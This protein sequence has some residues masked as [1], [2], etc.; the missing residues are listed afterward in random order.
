MKNK[1]FNPDRAHPPPGE[2]IKDLLL[3]KDI[4]WD[5]FGCLMGM[6]TYEVRMLLSGR[7]PIDLD[8][9][10]QLV[11]HLGSNIEFW[12]ELQRLYEENL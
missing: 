8:I 3:D 6:R 2:T 5:E 4:S 11:Y 10:V 7:Y 1:E 9:A 12:L